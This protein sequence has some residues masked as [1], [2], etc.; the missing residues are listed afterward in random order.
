MSSEPL[1]SGA[2]A[3]YDEAEKGTLE[4]HSGP[5][6]VTDLG[7]INDKVEMKPS[8][9]ISAEVIP[10][11]GGAIAKATKPPA[12]KKKVSRWI[13]WTLWFNTYRYGFDHVD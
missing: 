4:L 1:P 10:A 2:I 5:I 8:A 3:V 13:L 12:K 7:V 6:T 9:A 11:A